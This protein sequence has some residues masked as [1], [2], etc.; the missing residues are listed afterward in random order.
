VVT[1]GISGHLVE[2]RIPITCSMGASI[3]IKIEGL[4]AAGAPDENVLSLTHLAPGVLPD[5]LPMRTIPINM[6]VPMVVGQKF[7]IV[8]EGTA[9]YSCAWFSGPN[10]DTYPGGTSF[11]S[12]S[13]NRTIWNEQKTDLPFQTLVGP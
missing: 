11:Y 5:D 10:A 7:A 1:A 13:P 2:I 4:T 9:I 3:D 12:E 8:A 6:P